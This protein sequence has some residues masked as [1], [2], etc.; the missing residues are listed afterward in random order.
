MLALFITE[1][2]FLLVKMILHVFIMSCMRVHTCTCVFVHMPQPSLHVEVRGGELSL[3][4]VPCVGS[5]DQ[6]QVIRFGSKRLC[7]LS[8]LACPL[9]MTLNF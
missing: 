6:T 9:R 2:D 8:L 7:L 1:D 5:G 4:F 3:S